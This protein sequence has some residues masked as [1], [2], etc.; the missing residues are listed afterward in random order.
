MTPGFDDKDT[1]ETGEIKKKHEHI[2][3]YF[4]NPRTEIINGVSTKFT[5]ADEVRDCYIKAY[6]GTLEKV[7]RTKIT[8]VTERILSYKSVLER[9]INNDKELI[10][11]G[12]EWTQEIS[13]KIEKCLEY[14][15]DNV[16]IFRSV[17]NIFCS[18]A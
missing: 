14:E 11:K 18:A 6:N 7:D 17:D 1:T 3:L 4:D 13:T 12:I 8:D 2:V 9:I 10:K 16:R 15:T 5:L